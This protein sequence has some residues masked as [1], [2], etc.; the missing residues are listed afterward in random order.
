MCISALTLQRGYYYGA[1]SIS[2]IFCILLYFEERNTI[3]T[4]VNGYLQLLSEN[5][6]SI[7]S[8]ACMHDNTEWESK[9]DTYVICGNIVCRS[10]RVV[11]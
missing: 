6:V 10:M 1:M 2:I 7:F 4:V 3:I 11:T 5:N 9:P 8:H